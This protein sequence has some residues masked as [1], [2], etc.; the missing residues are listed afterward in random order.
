MCN[1]KR[2]TAN[3]S[4]MSTNGKRDTEMRANVER[5]TGNAIVLLGH[6]LFLSRA[7]HG[8]AQPL[9]TLSSGEF[10]TQA[11]LTRILRELLQAT[12]MSAEQSRSYASHS[13]RIG[14]AM[15]AAAA[16]FPDWLIQAVGR[17]RSTAYQRYIRSPKKALL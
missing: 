9:F 12:W 1:G 14:A 7:R 10:L 15:E 2:E 5:E 11:C 16:G 13:L 17:W 3:D 4:Q 8:P 6:R